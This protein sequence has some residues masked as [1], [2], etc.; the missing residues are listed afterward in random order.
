MRPFYKRYGSKWQMAKYI[1]PPRRD[2]VVEPFAGS[3]GYSLYWNCRNVRLYD[4]DNDIIDL[5][6]YLINCTV[7]DITKL[8]DWINSP[9]DVLSLEVRAEQN[10]IQRWLSFGTRTPIKPDSSL[11]VYSE[12]VAHYR[13][14]KPT[15]WNS[16]HAASETAMWSPAV[17]DRI[18]NQ[19]PLIADWEVTLVDDYSEIPNEVAHY[20][21]DPPYQSQMKVYSKEHYI[22]YTEL[23]EWC[24]SRNGSVDVCE[25]SGADWLP[26]RPLK[27][28][29]NLRRNKY[30][31]MIWRNERTELF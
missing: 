31:E 16:G 23:A 28:N 25:Q 11:K 7:A 9:D 1:G 4:I 10:L 19:K 18:I 29:I 2:L 22:D 14:G 30:T 12:F 8:P 17:K 27:R 3:A 26:F 20:H 5:W 24:Q 21:I 6:I 13:D 15:Q